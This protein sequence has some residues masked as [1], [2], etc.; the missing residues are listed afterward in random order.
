MSLRTD[1]AAALPDLF[2]AADD[3]LFTPAS[4]PAVACKVFVEFDVLLQPG[5]MDAQIVGTGTTIEALPTDDAGIGIGRAPVRGETFT[6]DGVVYTVQT[7]LEDDGLT[8]K[9]VV[10]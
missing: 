10:T 9:A 1:L 6:L 4:G 3:A 7:I 8:V 5:G 2:D